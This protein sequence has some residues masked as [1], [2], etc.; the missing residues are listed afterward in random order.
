MT[1]EISAGNRPATTADAARRRTPEERSHA[2]H[3]E[4]VGSLLRP[5]ALLAARRRHDEGRL[6]AA[7]LHAA[8]DRAIAD[9][10]DAQRSL[11]IGVLT[12]GEFRRSWFG[13]NLFR[14]VRG[15]VTRPARSTGRKWVGPGNAVSETAEKVQHTIV[16]E[17]NGS[18]T[19]TGRVSASRSVNGHE[20][21]FL[22]AHT[23]DELFKVTTMAPA[24]YTESWFVPGA[25]PEYPRGVDLLSDIA[26][27]LRHEL[28]HLADLGVPY[29]Q[30]DSLSYIL[31]FGDE[32][33]TQRFLS[34]LGA[35]REEAITALLAADNSILDAA[36][37]HGAITSVHMCRGN[38][39]SAWNAKAGTY[40]VARRALAELH[41]DRLL[42]E[43]DT[44]RA[45][46]F[47]PLDEVP[48]DTVVVLGLVTSKFAE[49]ESRDQLLQRIEEAAAHHPIEALALSPQCGFAS[50]S[51][52]NLI[53]ID[54]EFRKLDLIARVA[55]EV[56]GRSDSSEASPN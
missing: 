49:L 12:D 24:A 26:Q 22:L 17:G 16:R 28:T 20:A 1:T 53:T 15:L 33:E 42:L 31:R 54:D 44:S 25:A 6:S 3:S 18:L 55:E 14:A 40:E 35:D 23:D 50:T 41:A 45:G 27:I 29:L 36:R 19:A 13:E 51:P 7:G 9:V 37:S 21:D 32:G 52:G 2:V 11:G 10:L 38:S 39:R 56:W 4:H 43:Y 34:I 46:G 47:E 30:L 48:K 8:E 5:P